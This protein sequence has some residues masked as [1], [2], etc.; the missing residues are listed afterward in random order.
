MEEAGAE[1]GV[2]SDSVIAG[3]WRK[4][5]AKEINAG[6][7]NCVCCGKELG[8][9]TKKGWE[10]WVR[11]TCKSCLGSVADQTTVSM[12]VSEGAARVGVNGDWRQGT[13]HEVFVT[14]KYE[15]IL[16][17]QAHPEVSTDLPSNH[18]RCPVCDLTCL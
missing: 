2:D 10:N 1:V 9:S 14:G 12:A 11:M 8:L 4:A 3:D 16:A 5:T 7:A 17:L 15:N 13:P 18:H 6:G